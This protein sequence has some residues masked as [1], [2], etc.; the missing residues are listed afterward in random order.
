MAYEDEYGA[1]TGV[2]GI[3]GIEEVLGPERIRQLLLTLR[4][5]PPELQ[6]AAIMQEAQKAAG[7][8]PGMQMLQQA[9]PAAFPQSMIAAAP[10]IRGEAGG[11]G[12]SQ[13]P[14]PGPPVGGLPPQPVEQAKKGFMESID[15]DRVK[16]AISFLGSAGLMASNRPGMR[17]LGSMSL[18]NDYNTQQQALAAKQEQQI[19][20]Q[21]LG[22]QRQQEEYKAGLKSQSEAEARERQ[23]LERQVLAKGLKENWPMDRL[24]AEVHEMKIDD[25]RQLVHGERAVETTTDQPSGIVYQTP[26]QAGRGGPQEVGRLPRSPEFK[27]FGEGGGFAVTGVPGQPLPEIAGRPEGAPTPIAIG[28][29]I[30]VYPGMPKSE[31]PP[32]AM[33]TAEQDRVV[34]TLSKSEFTSYRALEQAVKA[35]D[36][37]AAGLIPLV[38]AEMQKRDLTGRREG[39]PRTSVSVKM[40]EEYATIPYYFAKQKHGPMAKID[41]KT[42]NVVE[43]P[44]SMFAQEAVDKHG[45]RPVDAKQL[46]AGREMGEMQ[47]LATKAYREISPLLANAKDPGMNLVTHLGA[48]AAQVFGADGLATKVDA[49][50]GNVLRYAKTFQGAA[51]Q[52]SNNDVAA[53]EGLRILSSDTVQQAQTK[54]R[55][56]LELGQTMKRISIGEAPEESLVSQLRSLTGVTPGG[57]AGR[58]WKRVP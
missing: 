17:Q 48:R 3:Q 8:Q 42:G 37:R 20:Q 24:V 47:N 16:Q 44:G 15:W 53:V 34:G 29:Q 40:A 58:T 50:R 19:Y 7:Q 38:D 39:A 54:T 36:Q 27:T 43:P 13:A 2:G 18:A 57:G 32:E 45:F 33:S 55:I 11:Y 21:R 6:R 26:K 14:P 12:G 22:A 25:L 46:Q 56:L 41:E 10:G 4:G 51:S 5:A 9:A 52:L 49:L 31:K 28:E 30:R 23:R 35:G 1:D